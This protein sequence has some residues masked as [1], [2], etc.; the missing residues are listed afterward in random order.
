V[1]GGGREFPATR[2][3]QNAKSTIAVPVEGSAES[4]PP[5]MSKAQSPLAQPRLKAVQ[6][7]HRRPGIFAENNK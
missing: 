4:L 7:K 6:R 3:E 2:D 5:S 1:E